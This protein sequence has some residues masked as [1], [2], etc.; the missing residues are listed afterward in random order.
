ML[1]TISI[2]ILLIPFNAYSA[3]TKLTCEIKDY[4]FDSQ[5]KVYEEM[6]KGFKKQNKNKNYDEVLETTE[7]FLEEEKNNKIKCS[8]NSKPY[9]I[10]T[11]FFDLE[12][13]ISGETIINKN[14][15][16]CYGDF[17]KKTTVFFDEISVTFK[18]KDNK[19]SSFY[20]NRETLKS[21]TLIG[22]SKTETRF[23]CRV[24]KVD[25]K[26]IKF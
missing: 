14:I 25:S 16:Y 13:T 2:L 24:E 3:L 23:K 9:L 4:N 15:Q 1:K 17:I 20:V 21:S 7:K 6:I 22:D 12:K 8:K 26:K 10:E 5:I 11:Y 18:D 19:F